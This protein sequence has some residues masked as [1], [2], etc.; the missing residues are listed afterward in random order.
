MIDIFNAHATDPNKELKGVA[1]PLPGCGDVRF[2][3]A[4]AN[5]KNYQ[6]AVQHQY[7]KHKAVIDGKGEEAEKLSKAIVADVMAKTVLLGWQDAEG[8]PCTIPYKGKQHAYSVE[9]AAA[10]LSHADFAAKVEEASADFNNYKLVQDAEDE[11]NFESGL[12]GSSSGVQ[13]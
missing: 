5:N 3:I 12:S 9:I 1:V 4:R 8:K 11:G 6:K 13:S 10:M 7:K 2:V